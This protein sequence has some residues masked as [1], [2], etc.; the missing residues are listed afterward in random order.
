M[1]TLSRINRLIIFAALAVFVC[2]QAR[3]GNR[4][5][6][7]TPSREG[8]P[9]DTVITLERTACY[10]T[11]PVYKITISADGNV[12]FEGRRFVRKAGTA[13][14]VIS[15]EQ[16]RE[17]LGAFEE[18]NFFELRNQ[19]ERPENGCK[20]WWTDN[21]TAITSISYNGRSKTVRHY[22]GCRGPKV[23]TELETLEHAIDIAVDSAQWVR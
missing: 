15:Q 21:P 19:Y 1:C 22:Y 9:G 3:A 8:V 23:L 7:S 12:S 18:I 13:K 11:C 2:G 17:L 14:S 10:G 4:L 5:Q 6:N 16:I 20:E